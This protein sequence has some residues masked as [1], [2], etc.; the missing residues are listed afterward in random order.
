MPSQGILSSAS[1]LLCVCDRSHCVSIKTRQFENETIPF[2]FDPRHANPL[3]LDNVLPK[4]GLTNYYALFLLLTIFLEVKLTNHI[5]SPHL[6][7]DEIARL[8]AASRGATPNL[9]RPVMDMKGLDCL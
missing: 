1:S 2:A 5:A 6:W 4:S 3:F 7:G 8:G 9:S